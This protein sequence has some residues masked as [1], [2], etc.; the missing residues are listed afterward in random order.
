LKPGEFREVVKATFNVHLTIKET[1][2]ILLEFAPDTSSSSSSSSANM[3]GTN[4]S[5]T[6]RVQQV[7][8]LDPKMFINKFVKLGFDE[9]ARIK[10]DML[11]KQKTAEFMREQDVIRKRR[12]AEQKM[13]L[14]VDDNF[15]EADKRKAYEKLK[16]ASAKYDKNAP[17]CV[18]L[19][20]F[21]AKSLDA[22]MFREVLKRTFNVILTPSELAAVMKDFAADD[23]D[24]AAGNLICASFLISFLKLGQDERNRLK[25]LQLE[26][27]RENEMHK[28]TEHN[29]KMREAE[30]KMVFK[31]DFDYTSKDETTGFA[32]LIA[33]AKK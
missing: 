32:K 30:E 33:A 18:S 16:Q 12:L 14:E 7:P 6:R 8:R 1:A 22:A 27:N 28:K 24:D 3:A 10:I 25:L 4:T 31:V 23:D 17:G 29:R 19:E 26:K 5:P 9:R 2:A 21:E 11:D 15:T 13:V 20:A